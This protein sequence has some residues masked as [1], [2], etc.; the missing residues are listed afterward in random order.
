MH[1]RKKNRLWKVFD[2]D[3]RMIACG[4]GMPDLSRMPESV[5]KA[6]EEETKRGEQKDDQVHNNDG[7][8]N[9]SVA[10]SAE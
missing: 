2:D 7:G 10:D 4:V 5:R 1:I 9:N 6:F 3:N 8:G